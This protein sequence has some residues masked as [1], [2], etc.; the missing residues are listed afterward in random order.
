MEIF[1]ICL[2]HFPIS[3]NVKPSKI[4]INVSAY[5]EISKDST[6][7]FNN[8]TNI[9][10]IC[11]HSLWWLRDENYIRISSQMMDGTCSIVLAEKGLVVLN[12]IP[13][14]LGNKKSF[15]DLFFTGLSTLPSNVTSSVMT[16]F[17]KTAS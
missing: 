5:F 10:E 7:L 4:G 8:F 6:E 13:S 16:E 3:K 2:E 12:Q 15:K 14:V 1:H 9:D 17:F 11:Q